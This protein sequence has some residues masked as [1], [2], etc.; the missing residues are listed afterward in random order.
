MKPHQLA[1][2]ILAAC[3]VTAWVTMAGLFMAVHRRLPLGA[4]EVVNWFM[5]W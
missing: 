1:V 4:G 2:L 3:A 5:G